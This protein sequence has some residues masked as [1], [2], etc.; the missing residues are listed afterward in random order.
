MNP[1]ARAGTIKK[2]V[3]NAVTKATP[4]KIEVNPEPKPV[5]TK[6]EIDPEP[7]PSAL[8]TTKKEDKP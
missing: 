5:P 6:K 3:S 4:T 7:K 8:V 1:F 2:Q